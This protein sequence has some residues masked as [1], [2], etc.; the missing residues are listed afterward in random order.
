[1]INLLTKRPIKTEILSNILFLMHNINHTRLENFK[2]KR[3]VTR[4]HFVF[5]LYFQAQ[6]IHISHFRSLIDA[7]CLA[8]DK[9]IYID[10]LRE[11]ELTDLP[12]HCYCIYLIVNLSRCSKVAQT[13]PTALVQEESTSHWSPMR[14]DALSLR[15]RHTRV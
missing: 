11:T 10:H 3:S 6:G 1:M 4:S 15:N 7:L 5:N 12:S 2:L 14:A 8:T 9:L 13:T